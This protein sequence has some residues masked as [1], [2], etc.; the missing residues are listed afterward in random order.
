MLGA[1]IGDIVGSIYEWHNHRSK[2]FPLFGDG[3]EFTDDSVMTAAVAQAIL[4]CDGD[5]SNLSKH[6]VRE[7]QKIG[8]NYPNC[9]YG[10]RFFDWMFSDNP[11]PYNSFGNG[12]AMRVS[13]V[14]FAAASAEQAK[15]MSL[16]VTAVTHNHLEGIKG[17]EAV[18]VSIFAA[19]AG[20]TLSEIK[21]LVTRDYY[22]IDFTL[23]E[24]RGTYRF[25]ETCQDT[26]P[27]AFEA[28]F[29]STGFEDAIRNA[30]SVGGDSDTLAAIT[31]GMAQA[32]YGIPKEIRDMAL[33][34]LD[35]TTY[36]ILQQFE[37]RFGADK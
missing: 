32:V 31:G 36:G 22:E 7:M 21:R 9:G 3:C 16:A 17:A 1:M 37:G 14:G 25:N 12:S 19:L 33:T 4:D 11:K 27:Q 23:D 5:Y 8:R 20:A 2:R 13:P 10:G 34:Y 30:I 29:E 6:A 24:I 15:E 28:L 18:A 35:K 26:V